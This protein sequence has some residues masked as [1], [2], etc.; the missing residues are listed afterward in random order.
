LA[1]TLKTLDAILKAS[2]DDLKMA[3]MG[4]VVSESIFTFYGQLLRPQE[5]IV[6]DASLM[7][8]NGK[9]VGGTGFDSLYYNGVPI[10]ADEKCTANTLIFLNEDY[11][12]WYALP[13]FGAKPV[14]YKSQVEGNDYDAP[15][16]LGFSW[17]D[18][19]IPANSGSVVGHVYFG[20]QFITTNP[21]RHGKLTGITGI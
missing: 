5:R 12:D 2:E 3:K 14:S 11:V 6:K 9:H 8:G 16:G 19:I 4:K 10:M 1:E 17:S 13:F 21:K 20:G 15:V 18:W 7:K